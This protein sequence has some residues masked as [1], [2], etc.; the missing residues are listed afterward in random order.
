MYSSPLGAPMIR[1]RKPVLLGVIALLF[2]SSLLA[3]DK[4]KSN[5][6]PKATD[7][8]RAMILRTFQSEL[9]FA[10]RYF[11]TGK[12]GLKID[13]TAA[14]ITPS[15]AEVRQ[16]VA[17]LGPAAKPGDRVKITNVYFKGSNIIFEING[18]PMK[19][20]KWYERIEISSVGGGTNPGDRNPDVDNLNARGSYVMLAFKD[21]IPSMQTQQIKELLAPVLDFNAF[22]A[23][24]AYSKSLPPI[25]QAALKEHR[26]LVGMDRDMV[27]ASKGRPPK[28]YRDRDGETDYEEW[29]YGEPPKE[30]EFIRFVGDRVVKIETMKVDGEK[31][32]RT[33]KEVDLDQ[34]GEEKVA[35]KE[36]DQ[37][38]QKAPSLLRPGEKPATATPGARMD[39][40]NAPNPNGGPPGGTNTGSSIPDASQGS[41]MPGPPVPGGPP[42]M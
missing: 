13:T 28:K 20:K 42:H 4:N 15:E 10:R 11:P 40:K 1:H 36:D 19:R 3:Q 26:A 39:P 18:G 21:Y 22:S 38:E 12:V 27:M 7:E 16:M 9:P 25:V 14:K 30:V 23:A 31:Q 41:P 33:A 24:E 32:V 2:V 29:I 34:G 8:D 37:P 35:K 6:P 5:K 17:D